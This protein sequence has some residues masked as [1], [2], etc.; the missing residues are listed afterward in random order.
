MKFY[1]VLKNLRVKSFVVF[2]MDKNEFDSF[3]EVVDD[4][5]LIDLRYSIVTNEEDFDNQ[6]IFYTMDTPDYD[7][8]KA[9]V[10]FHIKN[11]KD[12]NRMKALSIEFSEWELDIEGYIVNEGFSNRK[13]AY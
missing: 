9:Y 5:G 2:E 7:Y 13:I 8:N 11:K 6:P 3:N 1:E 10:I 12:L 4:Y